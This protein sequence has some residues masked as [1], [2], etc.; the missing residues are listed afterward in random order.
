MGQPQK[1]LNVLKNALSK[2]KRSTEK[3]WKALLG[4]FAKKEK[5]SEA[6]ETWLDN[7]GNLVDFGCQTRFEDTQNTVP[8]VMTDYFDPTI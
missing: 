1:A 7:A 6:D 3:H 4:R 8:T 5:L 2:L